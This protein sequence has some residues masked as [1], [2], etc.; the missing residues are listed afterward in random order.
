M[1]DNDTNK[2]NII[3]YAQS[4]STIKYINFYYFYINNC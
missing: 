4:A 1:I 2:Y 3:K